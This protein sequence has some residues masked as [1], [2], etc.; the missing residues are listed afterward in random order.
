VVFYSG[1]W[2]ERQRLNLCQFSTP[3]VVA[4]ANERRYRQCLRAT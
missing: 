4:K 2:K 3:L 1:D